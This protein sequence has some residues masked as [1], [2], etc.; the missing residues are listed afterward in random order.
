MSRTYA[1]RRAAGLCIRC[2]TVPPS[3][4]RQACPPCARKH[5]P[6][7]SPRQVLVDACRA[8]YGTPA[9]AAPATGP[10]V[11][12]CGSW[13]KIERIPFQTLCCHKTYF[14]EKNKEI[15]DVL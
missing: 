2:G 14:E 11:A 5:R 8:R 10:L 15:L 6:P 9:P 12:C 4:E 3:P 1:R 7:R 13:Q